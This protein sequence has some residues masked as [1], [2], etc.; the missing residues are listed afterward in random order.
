MGN[1]QWLYSPNGIKTKDISVSQVREGHYE[2]KW[3]KKQ[4]DK[5]ILEHM[6]KILSWHAC[7]THAC[8]VSVWWE[9][10]RLGEEG[11]SKV[12]P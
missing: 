11:H 10:C 7:W 3:K 6:Y 9:N 5:S 12:L 1:S 2:R 8:D 4:M